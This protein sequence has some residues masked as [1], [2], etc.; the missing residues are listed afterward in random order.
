MRSR[1]SR[2]AAGSP[3]SA[4]STA[5]R[6]TRLALAGEQKPG[7]AVD[8]V[9]AARGIARPAPGEPPAPVPRTLFPLFYLVEIRHRQLLQIAISH[10]L[11]A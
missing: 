9:A 7:S 6:V 10:P 8:A 4:G 3:A 11:M 1:H 2:N 5:L